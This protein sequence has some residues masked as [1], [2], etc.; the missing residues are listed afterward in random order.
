MFDRELDK[1][2]RLPRPRSWVVRENKWRAARHGMDAEIIWGED[3]RLV[4]VRDALRELVQDLRATAER[5]DCLEEL[6]RILT[7][8][9][10][11]P[12]CDRQRAVAA[13]SGGDLHAVVDSLVQEFETDRPHVLRTPAVGA[14]AAGALQ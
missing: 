11:G 7:V 4:P 2:Y 10:V 9:E 1:G 8:V 12:S 5:L 13:A 14:G 3:N 6:E